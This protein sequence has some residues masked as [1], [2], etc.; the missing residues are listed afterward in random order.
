MEQVISQTKAIGEKKKGKGGFFN[1]EYIMV[2]AVLLCFAFARLSNK[3]S[4]HR[5]R[6]ELE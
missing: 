2:L 4:Q 5:V 6:H 3:P 1:K